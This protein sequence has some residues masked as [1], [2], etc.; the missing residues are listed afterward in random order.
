MR[1]FILL[2]I[3]GFCLF[4]CGNVN[5][6]RFS[7][8]PDVMSVAKKL[9][10][11]YKNFG[12]SEVYFTLAK[13]PK[14]WYV[15]RMDIQT[16]KPISDVLYWSASNKTYEKISRDFFQSTEHTETISTMKSQ[17]RNMVYNYDHTIYYGYEG[18]E[19]D[20]IDELGGKKMNDTLYEAL[21]RAYESKCTEL[22]R[23]DRNEVVKR[24]GKMSDDNAKDFCEFGDKIIETYQKLKEL[25]P[26]YET[27]VGK[28]QTK[29]SNEHIFLWSE[30]KQA[31]KDKEADQF[32]QGELYDE[33][34]INFAKN[35]LSGAEKDAIIFVNGDNDTYPLWYV[36][37]KMGI[38]KDIA[39]INTSLINIPNWLFA[40][41]DNYKFDLQF[42]EKFYRNTATDAVYFDREGKGLFGLE[43]L[44]EGLETNDP[45]FYIESGKEKLPRSPF[46]HIRLSWIRND[47][48]APVADFKAYYL[49]KSDVAIMDIIASNLAKRPIYFAQTAVY[50]TLTD[51]I[52]RSLCFDGLLG[53]I[54]QGYNKGTFSEDKYYDLDL[55]YNNMVTNYNY[56]LTNVKKL[57]VEQIAMNYV[58]GFYHLSSALLQ[59]GDTSKSMNVL[60]VAQNKINLSLLADPV[61]PYVFGEN[62]CSGGKTEEGHR[63]FKMSMEK[64]KIL[65]PAQK[66]KS[67]LER[68]RSVLDR[69]ILNSEKYG[70]TDLVKPATELKN[71]VDKKAGGFENGVEMGVH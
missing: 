21:A 4:S 41:R 44:K 24:S 39:V 32:L 2:L 7:A 15:V 9:D 30:L 18:W 19:N 55:F 23:S 70:F 50:G 46:S 49:L 69:I 40:A 34:M 3:S 35:M 20:V 60:A 61:G 29:M 38:R 28:V 51:A 68:Y 52:S 1:H 66:D 62:L 53:K 14:G 17:I 33:L 42:S 22:T 56:G 11:E 65:F 37:A 54:V 10:V 27:M 6:A 45:G 58:Y 8:Y 25:N 26:D 57:Q 31:G 16:Q 47:S 5:P 59:N 36:Q 67:E 64:I 43:T 12:S 48:L 13:K 63:L 71:A